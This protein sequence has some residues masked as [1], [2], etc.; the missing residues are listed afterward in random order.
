MKRHLAM[1]ALAVCLAP[2]LG[3]QIFSWDPLK[4]VQEAL[5]EGVPSEG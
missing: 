5:P 2:P 1:F 3:A 4:D